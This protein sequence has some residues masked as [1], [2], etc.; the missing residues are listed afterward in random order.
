MSENETQPENETEFDEEQPTAP[1][2]IVWIGLAGG[3]GLAVIA[4]VLFLVVIRPGEG[5]T[6]LDAA[7]PSLYHPDGLTV[8]LAPGTEEIRA[9]LTTVPRE[10]FLNGEAGR[11]WETALAALPPQVTPLSP[12][13]VVETRGEGAL[14]ADMAIPNGADPMALLDLYRWDDGSGEWVFLPSQ[15]NAARQVITFQVDSFPANVIAAHTVLSSLTAGVVVSQGGPDLGSSYG[16]ALLEGV[17]IDAA[18]QITGTPAPSSSETA[19][20][21]VEN[22]AGGF[23]AYADPGQQAAM[24]EGLVAL[25]ANYDGLALDFDN[26]EGYTD[27]VA[28]LAET[29][30]EQ[31][32]RLDVMVRGPSLAGYNLAALGEGAD[33]LWYAPGDNPADYLPTGSV[34]DALGELVSQVDRAQVGLVVDAL[35][36]DVAEGAATPITRQDALALFG[37]V[38]P[39]PG[40][41]DP[42][43]PLTPGSDL[44]VR[45]TGRVESM[46]F[47]LPLG[48]NYLTYHDD[49]GTL[50]H[51]YFAS[52]QSL[53]RKLA[54]ARFYSL[55]AVAVSGIAHP[56]AVAGVEE[57]V[58]AFLN[59]QQLNSPPALALVWRVI[60][61]AGAVAEEEGDLSLLQFLWEV[62]ANPGSYEIVAA[63]DEEG[64]SELGRLAVEVAEVTPVAEV[65]EEEPTPTATP[66]PGE[67]EEPTPT[68]EPTDVPVPNAIAA[69]LFELGGQTHTLEHPDLMHYAGMTWVKFQHKWGPGDDPSGSVGGRIQ[70]AHS[71]GFK[72][73]LSIPGGEHPDSID[74]NAYVSY[75]GGVAALGPDAIEVWNEMNL[76]REWPAGQ[77]DG[78]A[79]VTNMLAP[80]YQAIKAANPGVM[81]ISGA[82]APTG[83]F[84][85]CATNGC[86]DWF[87]IAQMADAGA[88]SYMDCVGAHYNEGIIPPSQ[89]SGDPRA[90][91]DFYSRYFYGMLNLYYGTFGKPVCFTELGYAS[92]EGYPDLPSTFSWAADTSVAEHAEWLAQAAVLASQSGQVRLMIIFSVDITQYGSDPQGAYAM[93][94]PGGGCPACDALAAVQP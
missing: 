68:P 37:Q 16:L 67:E 71:L 35:N 49:G 61:E 87:Y 69:G 76:D 88:G 42:A 93:I 41:F 63:V 19:L 2:S 94:R 77:I 92:P 10:S 17:S 26:G 81:V 21:L 57:G 15:Q 30:H 9:K 22:R 70:Q 3:I 78:T 18:G 34:R 64:E 14:G 83:A 53:Q 1:P 55:G 54:W 80:A 90:F 6:Q 44:P 58:S 38:E 75:L 12:I 28:A 82:P 85:G 23:T 32:K 7:A 66:E 59:Q 46:G 51:V 36:V 48:M 89:T 62:V 4:L 91:G 11:E 65:P 79:Y 60:G 8:Y 24:I 84:G 13:Y 72:V 5:F 20:P 29:L 27:F 33:M 47:D 45:L 74:Y 40:Y 31:D 73:L 50:H 25:A 86:D 39:I 43:I 52:A 56:D